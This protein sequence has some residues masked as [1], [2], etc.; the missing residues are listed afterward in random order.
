V[1]LRSVFLF[2]LAALAILILG[3]CGSNSYPTDARAA[4]KQMQTILHRYNAAP[5]RTLTQ[6]VAACRQARDALAANDTLGNPPS[7]GSYAEIGRALQ[8]A[9]DSE[10]SGFAD[11]AGSTPYDY[12]RMVIAQTELTQAN[13]WLVKSAGLDR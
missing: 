3:G 12:T 1:R 4:V 5:Q 6:T 7:S 10:L 13:T 2:C 8:Q 11:C 9:Y